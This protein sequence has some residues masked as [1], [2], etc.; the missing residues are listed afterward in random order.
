MYNGSSTITRGLSEDEVRRRARRNMRE[1]SAGIGAMGW[2]VAFA[3][4]ALVVYLL[5]S[6]S[7]KAD[8][9]NPEGDLNR[10]ISGSETFSSSAAPAAPVSRPAPSS[11]EAD[12]ASFMN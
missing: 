3:A 10:F 12:F 11:F 4:I 6:P 7:T 9:S 8:S 2:V 1:Q 5:M